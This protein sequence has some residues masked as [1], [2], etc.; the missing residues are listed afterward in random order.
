[1]TK[2]GQSIVVKG[3]LRASEDVMI[4]GRIDGPVFCETGSVILAASCDVR[5]DIIGRDVTV[6]GRM[7]GKIVASEFVDLRADSAVAGLI[8]S[9]R[10]IMDDG[11]R[12][13]GRVEPQH[14]EAALRVAQYQ[15]RKQDEA[16][17]A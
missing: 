11:A 14:L 9:K 3:E 10:L 15:Q 4:E 2:L 16:G 12:F 7:T 8:L 13:Q 17:K 6:F 1:M 5:G